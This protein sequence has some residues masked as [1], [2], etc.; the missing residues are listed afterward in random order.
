VRRTC[1]SSFHEISKVLSLER[2]RRL[3]IDL[4]IRLMNDDE[5]VVRDA[6]SYQLGGVIKGI[7]VGNDPEQNTGGLGSESV[8][9]TRDGNC[10]Q[11]IAVQCAGTN[12]HTNADSSNTPRRAKQDEGEVVGEGDKTPTPA[13]CG[14]VSTSPCS[15]LLAP[16]TQMLSGT[17]RSQS[18]W[19]HQERMVKLLP[20]VF[21]CF[22][23]GAACTSL[24]PP[25]LVYLKEGTCRSSVDHEPYVQNATLVFG[26]LAVL[27]DR[28][29]SELS[30]AIC[31]ITYH[32]T[33]D[34]GCE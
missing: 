34:C 22:E 23:E 20:Q 33:T 31:Q 14:D 26:L 3:L 16:L 5:H 2:R 1:A 28:S 19:R 8:E 27:V 13:S 29:Q 6:L 18:D 30:L 11:V 25:L 10:T 4:L 12:T 32:C 17:P 21:T 15:V 7:A 24:V 9:T